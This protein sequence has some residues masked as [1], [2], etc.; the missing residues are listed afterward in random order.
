[1]SDDAFVPYA[2]AAGSLYVLILF[3]AL[4]TQFIVC[5][6]CVLGAAPI[7][8]ILKEQLF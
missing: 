1:M 4:K 6:R 3:L 7:L 5:G 2:I 8:P